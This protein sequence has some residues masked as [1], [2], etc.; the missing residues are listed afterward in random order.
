MQL[1]DGLEQMATSAQR[2]VAQL[3][4]AW[5]LRRTEVTAAIVG[6]RNPGQIEGTAAAADWEL[7]A[8]IVAQ[9]DKLLAQRSE[10]ITR[11]GP[12][13]SGRV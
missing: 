2:S 3:T 12:I 13:D 11:L 5:T 1:A 7:S 10:A 6:A 4:I 9:I 8:E